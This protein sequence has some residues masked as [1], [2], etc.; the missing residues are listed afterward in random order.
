[1]T[2]PLRDS[3]TRC[4]SSQ[5]SNLY[6]IRSHKDLKQIRSS[7]GST[8]KDSLEVYKEQL[9]K[10]AL[11]R[12]RNTTKYLIVQN[13]FMRIGKYVFMGVVFPPYLLLYGV[14]KWVFMTALPSL[15]STTTQFIKK[16]SQVFKKRFEAVVNRIN[17][18]IEKTR[19]NLNVLIQP[20]LRMALEIKNAIQRIRENISKLFTKA[21]ASFSKF[22]FK[23][24]ESTSNAQFFEAAKDKLVKI[25]QSII[26]P[27]LAFSEISKKGLKWLK[28]QSSENV[29]LFSTAI[30]NKYGN[31]KMNFA[32]GLQSSRLSARV[33]TQKLKEAFA[34]SIIHLK[35]RFNQLTHLNAKILKPIFN[36]VLKRFKKRAK[37]A[38]D[39]FNKH[40]QKFK[41]A[42]ETALSRLKA[43]SNQTYFKFSL[44]WLPKSL[45]EKLLNFLHHQTI[46]KILRFILRC[47]YLFS[48]ILFKGVSCLFKALNICFNAISNLWSKAAKNSKNFYQLFSSYSLKTLKMTGKWNGAA[49]YHLLVVLIMTGIL[50]KWGFQM[51]GEKT[52]RILLKRKKTFKIN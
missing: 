52:T 1:M 31:F 29:K 43:I 25:R 11:G 3:L 8:Q 42:I 6:E 16:M 50:L 23:R 36:F 24:K 17:L 35:S 20:I 13:G 9:Q 47:L 21:L 7:V 37:Q 32:S 10:E 51:A 26:Q 28:T 27:F 38:L 48:S 40:N 19:R 41:R 44:D 14:P 49:I 30:L 34:S 18:A 2:D 45:R 15:I 46:Q 33:V 12:L 5:Y 39:F 22:K 4:D